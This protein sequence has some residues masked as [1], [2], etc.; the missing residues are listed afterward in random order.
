M[1][2]EQSQQTPQSAQN[3]AAVPE[4]SAQTQQPRPSSTPLSISN[5]VL[6]DMF[7]SSALNG[8]LASI[9]HDPTASKSHLAQLA[10]SYADEMLKARGKV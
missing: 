7:A 10:F 6:R 2:I 8:L 3:E 9:G 4:Q 1:D 5:P